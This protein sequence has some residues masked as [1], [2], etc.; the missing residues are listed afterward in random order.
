MNIKILESKY[1]NILLNF[2]NSKEIS[3]LIPI[4]IIFST[5]MGIILKPFG[6]LVDCLVQTPLGCSHNISI[7]SIPLLSQCKKPPCACFHEKT[8]KT[9]N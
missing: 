8:I 2:F 7:K 6:G 5:A 4:T 9:T 1:K 3:Y